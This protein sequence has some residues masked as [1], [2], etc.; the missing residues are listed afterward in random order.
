M[1]CSANKFPGNEATAAAAAGLQD[2]TL[3]STE[4]L[5]GYQPLMHSRVARRALK[6]N[7]SWGSISR[8]SDLISLWRVRDLV[9]F[10]SSPG[11]FMFSWC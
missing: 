4:R 9:M 5:R 11:E 7:S 8:V 2:D 1:V 6:Q 10:E 3:R